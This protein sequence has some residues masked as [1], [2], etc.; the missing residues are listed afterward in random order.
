MSNKAFRRRSP[1][2][3]SASPVSTEDR[4]GRQVVLE[5]EGQ[6]D[7]PFLVDLSHCAKWDFQDSKLDD[8]HPWGLTIPAQP[9]QSLVHDGWLVN[10]M[11]RT[12]AQ[13]WRIDGAD[14]SP[15]Q[16]AFATDI[17][18]GLCLLALVGS[19]VPVIME[20]LTPLDIFSPNRQTPCLI[21]GP[22][23]HIPCQLAPDRTVRRYPCGGVRFFKGVWANHG[24]GRYR[25]KFGAWFETRRGTSIYAIFSSITLWL[26]MQ[27][28]R[29]RN[30]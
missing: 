12:Q 6:G 23:L 20:R 3:F 29:H 10:R 30:A 5:Y 2:V 21:Q 11:N 14:V 28:S 9:G 1:V 22:V 18:D 13:F 24:R 19:D 27:V 8:Q 4:Q 16:E 7:G 15:P 17:T 26:L 25:G